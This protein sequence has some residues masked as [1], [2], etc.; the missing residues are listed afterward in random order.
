TILE[1]IDGSF[2]NT[3]LAATG[4]VIDLPGA[5]GRQVT[6]DLTMDHARLEDVLWLA[7]KTPKAPMTG[8]LTIKTKM[9]LPPGHEDVVRK[10]RL[11]GTFLLEKARFTDAGVQQ[12]IQELSKRGRG[13]V[14]EPATDRVTSDFSG[15]FRLANG[16]LDIPTVSFDVPGAVVHLSGKYG[17]MSEKIDFA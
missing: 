6:L 15:A 11:D 9:F 14:A 10:L 2:L 17:L 1:R 16:T 7:V 4:D 3:S 8:A 5:P 12:K 13:A